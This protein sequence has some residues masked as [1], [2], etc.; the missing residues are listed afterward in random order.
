LPGLFSL[1]L[2][3]AFLAAEIVNRVRGTNGTAFYI[4]L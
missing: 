1:L 2:N 4:A 3:A